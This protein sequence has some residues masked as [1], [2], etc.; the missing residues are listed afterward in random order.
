MECIADE[1][2]VGIYGKRAILFFFLGVSLS[3]KY[4]RNNAQQ[5]GLRKRHDQLIISGLGAGS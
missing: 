5:A 4:Q 3:S 2:Q 1:A